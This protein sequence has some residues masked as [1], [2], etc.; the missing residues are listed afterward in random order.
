MADLLPTRLDVPS[1]KDLLG[2]VGR[3]LVLTEY[4]DVTPER[5]HLFAEA[6]EDRQWIHTDPER[7]QVPCSAESLRRDFSRSR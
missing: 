6:T 2:M 5:I 3:D 1:L 7:Q 4:L